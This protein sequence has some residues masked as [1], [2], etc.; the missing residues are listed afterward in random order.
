MLCDFVWE[1]C[2]K[3]QNTSM[4]VSSKACDEDVLV[5]IPGKDFY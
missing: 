4:D 1:D 3:D 2:L 5:L